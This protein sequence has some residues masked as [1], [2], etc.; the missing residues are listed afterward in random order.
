MQQLRGQKLLEGG[1]EK[2]VVVMRTVQQVRKVK[3]PVRTKNRTVLKEFVVI[4]HHHIHHHHHFHH[5]EKSTK[6]DKNA[7][8]DKAVSQI[9]GGPPHPAGLHP[10][11]QMPSPPAYDGAGVRSALVPPSSRPRAA[12]SR[13][14][15]LPK[16]GAVPGAPGV[17]RRQRT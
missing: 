7:I 6:N 14:K 11:E 5:Y 3:L 16:V 8:E 17:A 12:P 2:D 1:D 10:D 4:D 13:R 9:E 15:K